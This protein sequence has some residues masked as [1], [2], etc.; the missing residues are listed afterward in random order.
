MKTISDT[1]RE[2][3]KRLVEEN[4]E[5]TETALRNQ[6]FSFYE[7]IDEVH[8]YYEKFGDDSLDFFR[9]FLN[10]EISTYYVDFYMLINH[11]I[12]ELRLKKED[13]SNL[14]ILSSIEDYGDLL[15]TVSADPSFLE[16][17]MKAS[18]EVE[19]LS[20]LGKV[21]LYEQ[22]E[23]E[24]IEKIISINPVFI[25]EIERYS[26]EIEPNDY[27]EHFETEL[28]K[29]TLSY[30]VQEMNG[31]HILTELCGFLKSLSIYD[32]ENY[33]NNLKD[34]AIFH[35]EYIK[36]MR[37]FHYDFTMYTEEE[38]DTMI[39]YF[40][41][42]SI[43][44][45]ASDVLYKENYGYLKAIVEFYVNVYPRGVTFDMDGREISYEDVCNYIENDKKAK[46]K[47]KDKNTR[48]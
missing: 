26:R 25:E 28:R 47:V 13:Y 40:E 15:A 35:Y 23:Q 16:K 17:M 14:D 24:D 4:F 33:I 46:E 42:V 39:T 36:Y 7:Y 29:C 2:R 10:L 43:P 34:M 20:F 12:K 38:M 5:D 37:D 1:F 22:L 11:K 6:L 30:E 21:Y 44:E 31:D 32:Y 45:L 41:S 27:I 19:E 18:L 8:S 9:L 3:L 48:I